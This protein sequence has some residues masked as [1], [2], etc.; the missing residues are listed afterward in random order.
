[1]SKKRILASLAVA[2]L[3]IA[4]L[5]GCG[6][7][8]KTDDAAEPQSSE[9]TAA[10]VEGATTIEMWVFVE[11]HKEFYEVMADKWNEEN[12]D[13]PI[14]LVATVYPY[15]DMHSKL[16]LAANSGEGLPDAVDIEL[17]KFA[18]FVK[19]D[20]T[21]LMALNEYAEP[22]LGE[23]VQARLDLYSR[24][25]EI[26]GYP[27]HVGA[28]VAFYNTE[29]LEAADIDYTTIKTW[30]DFKAAGE[31]YYAATGQPMGTANTFATW[32]DTLAL[33]QEGGQFFTDGGLGAVDVNNS[34]VVEVFNNKVAMQ[35][36]GA[37]GTIPGGQPDTEEAYGVMNSG[38][39][40]AI[41]MPGWMAS[42]YVDYMPDLEGKVAIAPPPSMP[43][44]DVTTI[45]GGGTGTAVPKQAEN[46]ELAAEWLAYAKL[47]PEASVQ[48]WEV[49]GFDPVNMTVWTDEELTHNPD[50]KFNQ[51]FLTN[52]FDVLNEMKDGIGYLES[53][54]NSGYPTL[55][56]EFVTVTLNEIFENGVSPQEA[57][58]QAQAD[59]ENELG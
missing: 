25:G 21:P 17:G 2:G 20:S 53:F 37:I 32:D 27:T 38:E 56:D 57:L 36:A 9:G 19:G 52:M 44:S 3:A 45:G 55:N 34:K 48:V 30:D 22:Y 23:V 41:I 7:G 43:G 50:N 16:Q 35:E 15:D 47:S 6:G 4:S 5:A 49:L 14:N 58:D 1:M 24:N 40:P 28:M 46:A 13:R 8:S 42:R 26:Y 51:Y 12:P 39:Y 31:K 10:D 11:L 33:A 54:T 29:A 59:L 18:N